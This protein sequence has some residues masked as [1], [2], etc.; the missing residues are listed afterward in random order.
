MLRVRAQDNAC[1]IAL[2][3]AVGGQDELIFDGAL[4]RARR[5]GRGRRTGAGVRGGA[6]RG[7]RRARRRDRAPSARRAPPR[8]RTR[9]RPR[10]GDAGARARSPAPAGGAAAPRAGSP[11][12]TTSSRCAARSSWAS[13]TTRGRTASA[14]SWSAC[15]AGIDS[16]LTAA[17]AVGALGADRVHGVSMPS[18]YSSEATRSDAELLAGIARHRLP[19]DP[20]RARRRGARVG[21][22][23]VVRRP[24]AGSHR[25]EPAGA[26]PRHAPDGALEQVRLAGRRD[27]QQ[28]GALGRLLDALRRPGG[29]LRAPQ[30]RLQDGR[31]PARPAVEPACRPRADSDL[32]HRPGAVGRAPRTT[33]GTRT[34]SRRTRSSTGCSR[35][36]SSST[37]RTRSSSMTASTR[38]WSSARSR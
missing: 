34:R 22:R 15:R 1:F 6:P 26:C 29:R 28:V 16:A 17:L 14:T 36:T 4:A 24:R 38:R 32:D 25:G 35:P 23:A 18:R 9:S 8:A 13:A 11:H 21:A 10:R 33:S 30:G 7:R 2:C 37:A 12:S 5:R 20:D 27:R 3:N 31:L 19:G